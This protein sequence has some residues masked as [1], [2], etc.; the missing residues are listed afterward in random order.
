MKGVQRCVFRRCITC[1]G[2]LKQVLL[3]NRAGDLTG[4]LPQAF[5]MRPQVRASPRKFSL[6]L[7]VG[8]LLVVLVLFRFAVVL[9]L[10]LK[11]FD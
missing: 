4:A 6:E 8:R 9:R 7:L 1:F 11:S 10:L 2:V 3:A 5:T